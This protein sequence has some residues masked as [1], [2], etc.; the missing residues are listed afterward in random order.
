VNELY[1]IIEHYIDSVL[2]NTKNNSSERNS[3]MRLVNVIYKKAQE[4]QRNLSPTNK[5]RTFEKK[6]IL[7]T[8][9][10]QLEATEKLVSKYILKEDLYYRP[11]RNRI[12]VNY[13]V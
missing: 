12:Q 11:K 9:F 10:K 4:L 7:K 5:P 3:Y 2:E 13:K 1:Y 8:T 6:E